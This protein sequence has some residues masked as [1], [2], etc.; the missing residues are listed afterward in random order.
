MFTLLN[1]L[2]LSVFLS[3]EAPTLVISWALA[4]IFYKFGSFT[5]ETAAFLITW[6]GLGFIIHR[7]FKK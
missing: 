6:W 1:R 5:L 2:G 3:R 7:I 4:E